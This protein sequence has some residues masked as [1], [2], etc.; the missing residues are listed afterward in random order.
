MSV[1]SAR[2]RVVCA[3][4]PHRRRSPG[5]RGGASIA[6]NRH[7]R[8]GVLARLACNDLDEVSAAAALAANNR[9]AH[10]WPQLHK[11]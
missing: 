6:A 1:E 7:A 9:A 5:C 3:D 11:T 10:K 4:G 8:L 2:S